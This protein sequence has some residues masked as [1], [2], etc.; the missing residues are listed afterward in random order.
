[1]Q[2]VKS[3]LDVFGH[4]TLIHCSGDDLQRTSV[5]PSFAVKE[6]PCSYLGLPLTIKKPTKF[7]L[8]PLVDKIR[9]HLPG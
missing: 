6:F 4:A 3:L 2:T 5:I 1:M 8:L 9:D 7:E